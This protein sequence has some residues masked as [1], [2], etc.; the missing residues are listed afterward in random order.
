MS[1]EPE[2]DHFFQYATFGVAGAILVVCLCYALIFMNPRV[3]PI[4]ALRPPLP[5]EAAFSLPPTWTPTATGT[6]TATETERATRTPTSTPD[7]GASFFPTATET[8]G[9]FS[10]LKFVVIPYS[11]PVAQFVQPTPKSFV[12]VFTA[13]A[14]AA[15]PAPPPTRLP[16]QPPPAATQRPPAPTATLVPPTFTPTP[17]PA[18]MLSHPPEEYPNCGTW[19]LSGTVSDNSG[20]R[21][22]GILVR[23]WAGGHIVGTDTTGTHNN[24]AGYWEWIFK[25]GASVQGQVAIVNSDGSLRSPQYKYRLTA[26]CTGSDAVNEVILDFVSSR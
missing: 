11:P 21:L 13:T 12:F 7:S 8:P 24:R 22:N 3:N 23:V 16:T 4:G 25:K 20:Q 6:P 5:T 10:I 15:P 1:I 14:P 2:R 26:N 9:G 17:Q 18:F 19:Y